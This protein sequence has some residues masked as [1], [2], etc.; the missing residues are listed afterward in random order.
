MLIRDCMTRHPILA[1]LTMRASEAQALM[2]ENNIRHLPVV[3]DGKRLAGL[4]T[5][6]RLSVKADMLG[7]LNVW[8]ISRFLSDQRVSDLM[9]K[10]ADLMTITPDRTVERAAAM[11]T[12][13]KIGCL[14]V[15]ETGKWMARLA[16]M[17]IWSWA[18]SPKATYC[19][20]TKKCS[21]C[22]VTVYG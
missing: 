13:H 18:L 6:E 5:R 20:A 12:E 16:P 19:A 1:P 2:V 11:M 8:E 14:P 22:P 7:S 4:I 10:V 3:G 9:V 21:A 17:A 15:V